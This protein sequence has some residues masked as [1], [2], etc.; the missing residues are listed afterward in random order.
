[1]ATLSMGTKLL[2]G[3]N[4]IAELTEI[5]GLEI[6]ADTVETTVLDTPSNYRTFAQG[7][8]DAGEVSVSGYFNATDS[9][10]QVALYNL[11]NSGVQTAFSIIFP[12]SLGAS[13][14]FNGIVTGVTTSASMEDLVSFEATIKLS[15]VPTLGLTASADLT[16]LAVTATGGTLSPSFAA[17]K[18]FYTFSGVTG[19]SATITATLTGASIK[20]FVDDVY[21]QDLTSGTA[22]NA[23]A[24]TLNVGRKVTLLVQET[25]KT[26][27]IY[28]VILVKTA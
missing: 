7:L 10:G 18:Y 4:S 25:A 6:S 12:S 22:S 5:S 19:T 17:G 2:I 1:M 16:A 13:W 8:K 27:K 20:L 26:Q 9:Q 3:A 28:E 15:G 14:S 21:A 23:I 11:L 24:L